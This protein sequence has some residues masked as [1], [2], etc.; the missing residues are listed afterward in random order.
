MSKPA[1]KSTAIILV[2][3]V[4]AAAVFFFLIPKMN[5]PFEGLMIMAAALSLID[6]QFNRIERPAPPGS[7]IYRLDGETL[8]Y[9]GT[10][11]GTW[12]RGRLNT[13]LESRTAVPEP[14]RRASGHDV[15]QGIRVQAGHD[16]RGR[17]RP[18]LP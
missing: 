16:H 11:P 6:D 8:V 17:N 7:P 18:R 2:L 1:R 3:D 4:V 12:L 15:G 9:A 13:L 5:R 14:A 10:V